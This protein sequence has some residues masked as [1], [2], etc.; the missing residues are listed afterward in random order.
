MSYKK[1]AF[2]RSSKLSFLKGIVYPKMK[3]LS[4]TYSNNS[5]PYRVLQGGDNFVDKTQNLA[6]PWFP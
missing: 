6:S 4:L 5:G 2:V 3:I 1:R